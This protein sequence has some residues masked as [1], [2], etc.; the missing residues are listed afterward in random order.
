MFDAIHPVTIH[1][2][3]YT[4]VETIKSVRIDC[5]N[6]YLFR[7]HYLLLTKTLILLKILHVPHVQQAVI[8]RPSCDSHMFLCNHAKTLRSQ[9]NEIF[10]SSMMNSFVP[11]VIST[12]HDMTEIIRLARL[13]W[14]EYA[15]PLENCSTSDDPVLAELMW[16]VLGCLSADGSALLDDPN[17]DPNCTFCQFLPSKADK[18]MDLN[19][20]KQQLSEKLDRNIRESMRGL[21]SSTIMMPGRALPTKNSNPYAGRLPYITKFLLLAAFLCQNKRKE[22]DANLFT[23]ANT[24]KS[25]R[26]RSNKSEDG[27]AY[28]ASSKDLTQRQPLFPLE[29]MLSVFA[30]I[31]GQYGHRHYMSYNEVGVTTVA[32]LGTTH[33]FQSISQL[34]A[35]GLLRNNGRA[36]FDEKH[37]DDLME[38]MSSKFS[39]TVCRDDAR[40]IASSVGFP[41]EKYCP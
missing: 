28:A 5:G 29:R 35:T 3:S 8:G 31:I 24:G 23:K 40:V 22:Q 37:D 32:Q 1:F 7:Y 13:L 20:L 27:S 30:S 2:D 26:R 12:T 15:T 41:L 11:S 25:K 16:K 10:Y 14:P 4:S 9:M 39:C 21:L 18:S 38:I 19:M 17:H 36:K 33:L 34:I 6:D